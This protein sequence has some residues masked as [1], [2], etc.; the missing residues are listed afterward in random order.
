MCRNHLPRGDESVWVCVPLHEQYVQSTHDHT[1]VTGRQNK[2]G[3]IDVVA[4][5]GGGVWGRSPTSECCQTP[6]VSDDDLQ[7]QA[8]FPGTLT[9]ML[10][11]ADQAATIT[12]NESCESI[13]ALLLCITT[14]RPSVTE[15]LVRRSPVVSAQIC[16]ISACLLPHALCMRNCKCACVHGLAHTSSFLVLNACLAL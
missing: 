7:A 15:L 8:W 5:A 2:L 10:H 11:M 4:D 1:S 6:S 14:C 9:V 16:C 13:L 3:T 12:L